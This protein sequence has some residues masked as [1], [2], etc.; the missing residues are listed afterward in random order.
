[1]FKPSMSR[2]P[3]DAAPAPQSV[4][5]EPIPVDENLEEVK[6]IEKWDEMELP[7]EVLRGVFAYGYE[8]PSPIQKRAICPML[9]GRD[10]IAQA[11]SGTGKTATF[12]IGSMS[13]IDLAKKQ[14][15]VV[16][17]SPTRELSMQIAAVY[18]G[19]GQF[20][21]GLKVVTLVGGES[22]DNNVRTLKRDTPHVV[23]GTPGRIFDMIRRR[24]LVLSQV[25][26]FILDEADEMLSHGFKEQVQDIFEFMPE[27]VQ[28]CIFSATMPGYVFD[29]T[30]KFM[31]N[32]QQIIV[33]VEQLTL[34]GI[35][36]HYIA[37]RDDVEKYE[38]LVDLYASISLSHC[39]IYANSVAR[40]HDLHQ[41]MLADGYPVC[42]IHSSMTKQER[43]ISMGDF[44]SGKCRM[45][46]SSNV[47]ARGIDVQQVS[48]VINF[49]IPR[50]VSTYLH[51][52]G[53]SGRWGRKGMG[54]NL[55]T[56]RDVEKMREIEQYYS[57][58]ITELPLE[59]SSV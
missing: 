46:I 30:N 19:I 43:E 50:D 14:V 10:L 48:C 17:L 34:E 21:T 11:Q 23:I 8:E 22:V 1:M 59:L 12:S 31:N 5:K 20:L 24:V 36:Q 52:I 33:K 4:R 44:R 18:Q 9:S 25:Q 29:V 26:T 13:G 28:T 42:S 56:E 6:I 32:P 2:A 3:P 39:I 40:V 51:R 15:Q 45:L 35:S 47:T 16:C 38:V 54:L 57:T 7:E 37:V 41:A 55:I 53:R 27:N 58:Q 49:D